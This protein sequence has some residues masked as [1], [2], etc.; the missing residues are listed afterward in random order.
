MDE[1]IRIGDYVLTG[2]EPAAVVIADSV[3]R[4]LPGVLGNEESIRG[5]SHEEPGRLGY[6]QYTRPAEYK[7]MK[8]PDVLL[9]VIIKK[10]RHGGKK[11]VPRMTTKCL[12]SYKLP[13]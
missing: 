1:E 6:P 11:C 9:G 8:V 12:I 4:L 2:G 5:E 7:G 13:S 3:A 10:S